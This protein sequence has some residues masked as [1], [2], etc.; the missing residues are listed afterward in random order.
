MLQPHGR[1][2]FF[3]IFRKKKIWDAEKSSLSEGLN[4]DLMRGFRAELGRVDDGK[5]GC[6]YKGHGLYYRAGGA[7]MKDLKKE[8]EEARADVVRWMDRVRTATTARDM[9]ELLRELTESQ[10]HLEALEW[11]MEDD[12]EE[13]V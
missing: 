9:M 3:R 6:P 12:E 10:L 5:E 11:I 13:E 2:G 4:R 8:L 7:E 1:G